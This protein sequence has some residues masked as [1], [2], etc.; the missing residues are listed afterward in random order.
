MKKR[1]IKIITLSAL[2][3]TAALLIHIISKNNGFEIGMFDDD[4]ME[5]FFMGL[6]ITFPLLLIRRIEDY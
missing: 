6:G 3:L 2:C 5:G 1:T 4:F